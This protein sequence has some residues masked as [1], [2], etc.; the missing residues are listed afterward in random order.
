MNLYSGEIAAFF[1]ALL[2]ALSSYF[3]VSATVKLGS[4]IV[5]FSR[6]VLS[7]V[8]F[9]LTIFILKIPFDISPYQL[10]MLMASGVLGLV[11]GDSLFFKSL[12]YLSARISTLV[13][14][15]SPAVAAI[16]AF[17][18]LGESL[19]VLKVLGMIVTLSGIALVVLKKEENT[20]AA[21]STKEIKKGITLAFLYTLG[22]SAG[23]IFVKESF[24]EKEINS[25]LA[26][27]IRIF[28]AVV[29]LL[30]YFLYKA[31]T[32]N[33]YKI[34]NKDFKAFRDVFIAMFLSVYIGMVFMFIAVTKIDIAV[35]STIIATIPLIQ[36][37]ISRYFFK[38]K[39][40]W[41]SITGAFITVG[42]IVI[43][44]WR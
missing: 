26:T 18:F 15:F 1:T 6:L 39:I 21:K 7:L 5:N 2:W 42:G 27:G 25:I 24:R 19:S 16:M 13:T 43:L 22:Q 34:F 31:K 35:A 44:F 30:P 4:V 14:S 9:I 36:L 29:V 38:E 23:L 32:I 8:L 12:E 20:G 37:V 3:F 33:P 40:T 10:W 41:R 11:V 17:I 28:P